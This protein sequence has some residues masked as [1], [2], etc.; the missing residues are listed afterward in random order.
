MNGRVDQALARYAQERPEAPAL[1]GAGL[2]LSYAEL[3]AQVVQLAQWLS[4]RGL[5]SLALLADNGPAWAVV[6]LAALHAGLRIVPIPLFFS[7]QQIAHALDDARVDAVIQDPCL[8]LTARFR[9]EPAQALPLPAGAGALSLWQRVPRLPPPPIAEAT[10]KITYTSGTTGEPRGVCLSAA[11]LQEQAAVLRA[12]SGAD[13]RDVH[14]SAL[15]LATLL[16]NVAGLYAP[17]LAGAQACLLPMREVGLSGATQFDPVRLLQAI[18][19]V[20][21]STLVLVPQLLQ[22]MVMAL[23][24]GRVPRPPRLR[25][26]AVGGAPMPAGLLERAAAL[27]IPVYEGYGLSECGSVVTL[28]QAGANRP[29]SVGRLLPGLQLQ[30]ADDGELSI[31][32][33]GHLGYV[34][35]PVRDERAAVDTGDLGRVDADGYVYLSGRKKNLFVTA[36]GRNVSPEW[37]ER[38]LARSPL[39]AQSVVF[40]EA[41]PFNAAVIV[42]PAADAQIDAALQQINAGLPDYARVARWVRAD[43]PFAPDNHQLTANG[44]PRREA[45]RA[46]YGARLDALYLDPAS[47]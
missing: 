24:S 29:G 33:R 32:G 16:E 15:P 44:R 8:P 18:H 36:F 42:S 40:G 13:A 3:H 45:I 28:N 34:G 2:V 39:I 17:L 12:A 37:V 21:A 25:F 23:E 6:D 7:G 35:D 30:I 11:V 10:Q 19:E 43:A 41:R 46:A 27:G 31:R 1:R 20:G 5:R 22:G 14:L 26:V 4:A 38:E 47:R 9:T